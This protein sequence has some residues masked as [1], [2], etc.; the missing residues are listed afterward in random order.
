MTKNSLYLITYI[1]NKAVI[2]P[3][4]TDTVIKMICL[5]LR[6]PPVIGVVELSASMKQN[7]CILMHEFVNGD[8]TKTN[9]KQGK[10]QHTLKPYNIKQN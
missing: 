7:S 5:L 3:T 9:G 4:T 2:H 8:F 6:F 1:A 10:K